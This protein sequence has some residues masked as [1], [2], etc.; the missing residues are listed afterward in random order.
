MLGACS[1]STTATTS[2][3]AVTAAEA[4][5]TT[6]T[7][8]TTAA[9]VT[10]I[11]SAPST[12]PMET[13][14]T[15]SAAPS[16][17]CVTATDLVP[18]E[19]VTRTI[20]IGAERREYLVRLPASSSSAPQPLVV[21][22]HGAGS[23][24]QQ[25]A[26]YSGFD[27]IADREGFV[28]ATPNGIEAARRLW[29]FLGPEDLAFATALVDQ[30]VTDACVDRERVFAAGI[31]SGAAMSASLACRASEVFHGF[32]LVAADFYQPALCDRATPRPM[33]IF[34]GTDDSVVPYDGGAVNTVDG[35]TT[36]P[37]EE[38]AADWAAHHGCDP[39]PTETSVGTDV[40][41]IEWTGCAAPIVFHR[42]VGGGHTWPGAE[43][44]VFWLGATTDQ[45]DASELI[46][47][48]FASA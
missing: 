40:I 17:P 3:T 27:P 10:T 25:Q 19:T 47:S 28:V 22:F 20:T 18:G 32:G 48:T 34:H 45:I 15:P 1:S 36:E 11:A 9:A 4:A 23:D 7:A 12:T 33:V 46:W 30:L 14:T 13:S 21:D 43:I 31:S 2:G 8:V 24:M 29:R 37:A 42:V 26:F 35:F 39:E 38:I 44:D 41:R 16:A 6:A 5:V